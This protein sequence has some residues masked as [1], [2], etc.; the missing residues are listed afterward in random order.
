MRLLG[1]VL[2]ALV[3]A[4]CTSAVPVAQHSVDLPAVGSG[5]P[6]EVVKLAG[7]G[8]EP[9]IGATKDGT[10]YLAG[11]RTAAQR[12]VDDQLQKSTDG[13]RT[14]AAIGDPAHDARVDADPFMWADPAT[15]RVY[16]APNGGTI[17]SWMSWT[18]D[19]GKTWDSNSAGGCGL[20]GQDHQKLSGGPPA[21]GVK[22]SGYPDVLYYAYNSL[23]PPVPPTIPPRVVDSEGAAVSVSLD[24]GKTWTLPV[25]AHPAG[26]R[27]GISGPVAVAPDGTAFLPIY[28]CDGV[29]VSISRDSGASWKET[30]H[31]TG[32]GHRLAALDPYV[33][34]DPAGNVFLAFEGKDGRAYL[35]ASRD[36]GKTWSAPIVASAPD[37]KA[38]E[39]TI[40]TALGDGS[41]ALA[42]Y[43][44][45]TDPRSWPSMDSSD[46]TPDTV[47]HMFVATSTDA[48]AAS[49][50][51]T[52]TKVTPDDDPVQRG[53]IWLRGGVNDCRN[54]GD[55]MGLAQVDG[56]PVLDYIDGCDKCT[57]AA[58][59]HRG[60]LVVA[61]QLPVVAP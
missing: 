19:A 16:N 12:G 1:L 32:A 45:T 52:T 58:D 49:P 34:V 53:C 6:F 46:A 42:Y 31:V 35:S 27:G 36:S 48:L 43:G 38:T 9:T 37:V 11:L 51:F 7:V 55:F 26:C 33:A 25:V 56:R 61:R 5:A 14:W 21:K 2:V 44:S 13:G 54:I 47:W 41:V 10:L 28:T 15:T 29:D 20:P 23:R 59:S 50:T 4:G 60:D 30:A 18:D 24:G 3:A 57:S 40:V 8:G 22:T 17:C 39:F